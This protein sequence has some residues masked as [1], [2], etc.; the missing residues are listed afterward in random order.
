MASSRRSSVPNTRSAT[1]TLSAVPAGFN[2]L[3]QSASSG[4]ITSARNQPMTPT[5]AGIGKHLDPIQESH[6]QTVIGAK[7]SALSALKKPLEKDGKSVGNTTSTSPSTQTVTVSTARVSK[8]ATASLPTSGGNQGS[9]A[10][11]TKP[12]RRESVG[13]VGLTSTGGVSQN[14]TNSSNNNNNSHFHSR[15][16]RPQT[17]SSRERSLNAK[18]Q[19]QNND[20]QKSPIPS[21]NQNQGD[22][23]P[24]HN[25][26]IGIIGNP[27]DTK[28]KVRP[29]SFWGGWWRF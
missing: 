13:G 8:T 18:N 12:A 27:G 25:H 2:P 9:K 14:Q 7:L 20:G 21:D 1:N 22:D 23:A 28:S 5:S 3:R 26:E 19:Q 16:S 11:I 24:Q 6:Q 4:I 17:P 15:S 29:K 10:A